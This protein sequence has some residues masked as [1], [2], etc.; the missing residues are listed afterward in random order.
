MFRI[1]EH[2]MAFFVAQGRGEFVDRLTRY[3]EN[4]YASWFEGMRHQE[5]R[6]WVEEAVLKSEHYGINTEPEVAQLVLLFMVLDI[7]ADQTTPWVAEILKDRTLLPVGKVRTLIEMARDR[8][9]EH[10][11]DVVHDQLIGEA[12]E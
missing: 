7:D 3:V 1:L 4:D 12:V 6:D 11:D 5:I 2:Q 8:S 10:I 9:V